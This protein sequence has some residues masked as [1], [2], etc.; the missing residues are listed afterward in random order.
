MRLLLVIGYIESIAA[1][2]LHPI[3]LNE[4]LAQL[5]GVE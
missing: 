2:S 5:R 4:Y 3:A 1:I